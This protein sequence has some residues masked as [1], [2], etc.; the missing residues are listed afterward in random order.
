LTGG[1]IKTFDDFQPVGPDLASGPSGP[2]GKTW[3]ADERQPYINP[4]T[5]S[6]YPLRRPTNGRACS[7]RISIRW[8]ASVG[9]STML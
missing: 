9:R 7:R 4:K 8:Y 2:S 3:P 1:N 5:T 6:R